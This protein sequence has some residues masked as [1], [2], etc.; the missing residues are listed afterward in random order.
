MAFDKN[1]KEIEEMAK[2]LSKQETKPVTSKQ[3]KGNTLI[4]VPKQAKAEKAKNFTMTFKPSVKEHLD[5][6]AKENNYKSS[7][8][9]VSAWIEEAYNATH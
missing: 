8:A 4:A 2:S 6:L 3:K 1:N 7:S 5:I 9:F